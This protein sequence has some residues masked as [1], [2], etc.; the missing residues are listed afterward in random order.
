MTV[1]SI[2]LT[3]LLGIFIYPT[4]IFGWHAPDLG[5]L[6][7]IYLI[8]LFIALH[9]LYGA[10]RFFASF[11]SALIFYLGSLYWLI[12]AMKNFGGL[13]LWESCGV[14]FLIT[15][16]LSFYFA[17]SLSL[18]CRIHERTGLPLFLL[19]A[20]FLMAA[21]FLRTYFP[22][23]GFPWSLPAY[24]QG[25]YLPYFQWVDVTGVYGLNFLVYLVNGLL[26]EIVSA[27]FRRTEKDHLINRFAILILLAMLSFFGSYW[28]SRKTEEV[29]DAGE[30]VQVAL[31][32]G[33]ID[34][35]L[36]WD[37]KK[38]QRHLRK[39]L[40]LSDR[41][42]Q[43][44]ADLVIWP[45][46]AFPYTVDL[47]ILSVKQIFDRDSFPVPIIFG[48]VGEWPVVAPA[49]PM[50]YNSAFLLGQDMDVRQVYHKQHLVPFGEYVPM[51]EWLT[52]ARRLTTAVGDF[53]PGNKFTLLE[54]GS[55]KIGT[56][57]CYEDIFPDLARGF[58]KTGANLLVNITNDAWYGDSSA[59]YQHLVFSQ[60]RAL[61]NRRPLL[62]ATNTGIT[63]VI[64]PRGEL[65][66]WLPPFKEGIL[67][68]RVPLEAQTTLYGV[69]GDFVGWLSVIFS[70]AVFGF[71]LFKRKPYLI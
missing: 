6:A 42:V 22:V 5:W 30:T 54:N 61:E 37:P 16:I 69:L 46:T 10:R 1:L 28:Q 39:Y 24:S 17:V 23:G 27:V 35:E 49:E 44:A 60:F 65:L 63:A 3:G 57:V 59:Q 68:K 48:A 25:A 33:N 53:T 18:A 45:E 14:L 50:V 58:A 15:L 32:Q 71:S 31:I 4:V 55:L 36:K 64:D 26:A 47:S 41:A 34:Q 19:S 7:W 70:V 38:A 43:D 20:S 52:F 66:N 2:L 62:R 29:S 12:A 21:D 51:R 11:F 40:D 56:L 67:L 13:S 8:P 9:R